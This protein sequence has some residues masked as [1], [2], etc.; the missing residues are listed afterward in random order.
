MIQQDVKYL[1][2]EPMPGFLD[3]LRAN[4]P[5]VDTLQCPANEIP[6]PDQSVKVYFILLHW[7]LNANFLSHHQ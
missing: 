6:L 7:G 5:G 3:T 2:T 1:A 4:C